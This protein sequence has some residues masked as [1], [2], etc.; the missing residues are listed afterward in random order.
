MT[1]V[2]IALDGLRRTSSNF[3]AMAV[4]GTGSMVDSGAMAGVFW[5]RRRDFHFEL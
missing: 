5:V 3:M 1:E 4:T 2:I